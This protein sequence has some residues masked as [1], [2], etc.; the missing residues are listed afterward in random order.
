MDPG[1]MPF[2]STDETSVRAVAQI[3]QLAVAPV[4][5]L[6]GI[7]AF[8]NVCTTRIARTVDRAREIEPLLLGSKG[9]DRRRL[10]GEM[11]MLDRRAWLV[12][13]AIFLSVLSAVLICIVVVLLFAATLFE[14]DFGRAIAWLF[15]GSMIAIGIGFS[16]FLVETKLTPHSFRI[17]R[18]L[19]AHAPDEQ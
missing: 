19:L 4:F 7:G 1:R 15:I 17:P 10:R 9:K 12:S 5:L 8:L 18:E 6:S 3:I 14:P 2:A 11:Q 13:W 16:I